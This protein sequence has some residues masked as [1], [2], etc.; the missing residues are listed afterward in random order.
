M[1]KQSL[2]LQPMVDS[3]ISNHF[4]IVSFFNGSDVVDQNKLL[5]DGNNNNNKVR[6]CLINNQNIA[7]FK[8]LLSNVDWNLV[9]L[10]DNTNFAY[11]NFAVIFETLFQKNFPIAERSKTSHFNHKPYINNDLKLLIKQKK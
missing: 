7:K 4:P 11:D 6:Y 5:N 10:S 1:S 2:L 8:Y 3:H 9:M